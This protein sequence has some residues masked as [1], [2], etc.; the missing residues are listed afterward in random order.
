ME[1]KKKINI[2]ITICVII[3]AIA[4]IG[5][6]IFLYT[7]KEFGITSSKNYKM[8]DLIYVIPK[9]FSLTEKSETNSIYGYEYYDYTNKLVDANCDIIIENHKP[10][11]LYEY[12]LDDGS[13]TREE[14]EEDFKS[15]DEYINTSSHL[16]KKVENFNTSILKVEKINNSKWYTHHL[17]T[18]NDDIYYLFHYEGTD[19]YAKN[20]SIILSI[21]HDNSK[22]KICTK[23]FN[24]FKNSLTMK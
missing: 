17:V 23:A 1:N 2:L 16:P 8:D 24:E 14:A 6:Y 3:G 21:Y 10:I 15:L 4:A 12:M 11:Y 5:I 13:V 19:D 18:K 22:N 7:R 20:Y 9:D